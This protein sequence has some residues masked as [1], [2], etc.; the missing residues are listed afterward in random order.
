MASP[1]F[2]ARTVETLAR[3]AAF[4]CSN[5]DCRANT[6]GP[7]SDPGKATTIGEAAHIF[8]ARPGSKRFR[9]AMT[10]SA[11]SAITN[12]IWLCCNCHQKVDSDEYRYTSDVLFAWR[13]QHEH[14]VQSELGNS[15]DR[16]LGERQREEL[17]PFASYPPLIRRIVLDK[18]DGWE[19]RLT[20]ELM[21]YLNEPLFRKLSDLREG[22]YAAPQE[23]I[24][25]EE[26]PE[27]VRQRLAEMS[28]LMKPL[29][30]L[31]RRLNQS[32]GKPGEPGSVEE[33]HH[34]CRLFRASLEQVVL[35]EERV[36]FAN[37]PDSYARAL[38]LLRD[39][40]GSQ[41]DKLAEI[42]IF[43][44][45][46]LRLLES[47]RDK[48]SGRPMTIGK[49]ITLEAS[50][51]RL[52]ELVREVKRAQSPVDQQWTTGCLTLLGV[53]FLLWL[54]MLVL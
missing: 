21:R 45:E 37:G 7:N 14:F 11:R 48:S 20:A 41:A 2:R 52:K 24:D 30:G 39:I 51:A 26:A 33:I 47:E 17:E 32:W 13:E 15:A 49:A 53:G 34:V 22:L 40:A 8:G 6:V 25:E 12:G 36:Y 19:W 44:D 23:H 29:D 27:W 18:P 3:R 38:R 42:P 28:R 43:M 1:D 35:F 16:I 5:P 46:L 4:L 9:A 54:M 10:D 50:E 31:V